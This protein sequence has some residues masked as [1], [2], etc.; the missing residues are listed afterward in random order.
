MLVLVAAGAAAGVG[1]LV[2][3]PP[4]AAAVAVLAVVAAALLLP[5]GR[6]ATSAA[7]PVTAA[8]VP[9]A[10]TASVDVQA[11]VGPLL[12]GLYDAI[13]LVDGDEVVRA[14]N[15]AAERLLGRPAGSLVGQSVIR[16]TRDH[17][18][19]QV[20]REAAGEAREVDVEGRR[21]MRTTAWRVQ[22][23]G[24]A[25]VLVMEELTELRRAQRA[26]SDLVANVSHELRTP[27]AAALALAETLEEGVPDEAQRARFHRQLTEE[28]TRLGRIVERLLHLSRLEQAA[29]GFETEVVEPSDLLETAATRIAPLVGTDQR[30]HV[31]LGAAPPVLADRERTLEVLANLL[32]NALRFSPPGGTVTLLAEAG[33]GEVCF[34]VRDE[35]PGILPSDRAR[36]FERFYTGDR[37]RDREAVGTG[38]GLAIARHIVA[39]LGGRI[40]VGD[41]ERGARLCFTLPVAPGPD[42]A[43]R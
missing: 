7:A 26:R 9:S 30:L 20:A 33:D 27:I 10:D 24:I 6:P 25:T 37:S 43:S 16:A 17:N 15:P 41:S 8:T 5:R 39:R 22:T 29:E 32:E 38:L 13:L 31:E 42:A 40:W 21:V 4:V 1:A 36:V 2:A 3:P 23:A 28:V 19:T 14:A 11:S 34:G 18:L 12:E 35:G